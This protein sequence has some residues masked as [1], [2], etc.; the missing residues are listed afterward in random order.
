MKRFISLSIIIIAIVFIAACSQ[1]K[2]LVYINTQNIQLR[3]LN[4]K[5]PTI[6]ANVLFY[7]P[8]KYKMQLKD[9]IVDL[10]INEQKMG[11]A[12]LENEVSIPASDSFALPL[13]FN[14]NMRNVKLGNAWDLATNKEF[15]LRLDGTAKAGK[16]GAFIKIPVKYIGKQKLNLLN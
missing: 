3:K 15:E 10:Y 7:N 14:I 1:P 9:A 13:I 12:V 11:V 6:S 8:N 16:V 5:Q 2:N 4:L